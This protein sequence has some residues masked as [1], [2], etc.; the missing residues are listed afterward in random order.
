M[1]V[2]LVYAPLLRGVGE[3]ERPRGIPLKRKPAA[4]CAVKGRSLSSSFAL[5]YRAGTLDSLPP[6][7]CPMASPTEQAL[8]PAGAVR[9]L[10]IVRAGVPCAH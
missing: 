8:S 5:R 3:V 7:P 2:I 9:R 1:Y 4:V 6:A 10:S